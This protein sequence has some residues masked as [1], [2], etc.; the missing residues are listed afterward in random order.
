M[1]SYL[2]PLLLFGS[3]FVYVLKLNIAEQAIF[4]PSVPSLNT[5]VSTFKAIFNYS[6][7]LVILFFAGTALCFISTI[8]SY[9]KDFLDIETNNLS[10][11][12]LLISIIGFILISVFLYSVFINPKGSIFV[13]RYFICTIPMASII[14]SIGLDFIFEIFFKEKLISFKNMVLYTILSILALYFFMAELAEI[15]KHSNSFGEA[16]LEASDWIYEQPD[17][18]KPDTLVSVRAG[19]YN[20][21]GAQYYLTHDG[22]RPALNFGFITESNYVNWNT[23]YC[24]APH[25]SLPKESE[26]TLNKYYKVTDENKSFGS[27]I[28]KYIKK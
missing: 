7:L 14:S 27:P 4:W 24:F 28:K 5:F 8:S 1:L 21:I 19:D 9:V 26:N 11:Y 22:A 6:D 17:A 18:H 23:V 16:Y 25:G 15:N 12:F 3:F 10:I 20:E 13:N 2:V